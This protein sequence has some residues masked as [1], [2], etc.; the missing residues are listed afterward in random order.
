MAKPETKKPQHP[1]SVES[2]H[3]SK[4]DS[5]NYADSIKRSLSFVSSTRA[6]PSKS[7]PLLSSTVDSVSVPDN[8]LD[9][10]LSTIE[11]K[12]ASLSNQVERQGTVIDSITESDAGKL[13]KKQK[14]PFFSA[15]VDSLIEV[16][17]EEKEE[18]QKR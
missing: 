7:E 8:N 18:D 16:V 9:S 13:A 11:S 6:T 4:P 1:S 2:T 15:L 17:F 14:K 10:M 3:R 12:L 5:S